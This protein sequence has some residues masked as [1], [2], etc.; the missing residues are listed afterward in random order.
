MSV[1]N[2]DVIADESTAKE[3]V[4]LGRNNTTAGINDFRE[5]TQFSDIVLEQLRS[6]PS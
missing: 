4:D 6:K 1:N 2:N 3:S 5:L